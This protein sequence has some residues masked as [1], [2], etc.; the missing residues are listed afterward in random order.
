MEGGRAYCYSVCSFVR[1]V[2]CVLGC[3]HGK[4]QRWDGKRWGI[5]PCHAVFI[6]PSGRRL[7]CV[8]LGLDSVGRTS[9]GE[10]TRGGHI[11]GAVPGARKETA[12]AAARVFSLRGNSVSPDLISPTEPLPPAGPSAGRRFVLYIPT[13]PRRSAF[14]DADFVDG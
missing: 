12:F 6:W 1:W 14:N 10:I 5:Q 8:S 3:R 2:R 13:C 4:M 9:P 7:R 11:D